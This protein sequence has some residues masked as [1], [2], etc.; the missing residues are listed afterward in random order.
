M[1]KIKEENVETLTRIKL[2]AYSQLLGITS[3]VLSLLF[4]CKSTT[5]LSTAKAIISVAYN[6][7]VTDE[8]MDELVEKH[9]EKIN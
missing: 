6:I 5:K 3:S 7:S 1:Y 2:T 4:N 8:K 9:F